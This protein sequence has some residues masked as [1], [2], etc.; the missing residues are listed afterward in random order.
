MSSTWLPI[1]VLTPAEILVAA[2]FTRLSRTR[3]HSLVDT[4]ILANGINRRYAQTTC[5]SCGSWTSFGLIRSLLMI[6][7]SLGQEK[8]ISACGYFLCRRYAWY[9]VAKASLRK[10]S[11]PRSAAKPTPRMPPFSARSCVFNLYGKILLWPARCRVSY[12]SEL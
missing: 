5:R 2:I 3:S 12:L 1:P 9:P 11:S 4:V 10:S 7:R 6:G 8:A